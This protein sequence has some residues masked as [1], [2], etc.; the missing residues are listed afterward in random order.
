MNYLAGKDYPWLCDQ[1]KSAINNAALVSSTDEQY[2]DDPE[3]PAMF[4]YDNGLY[5]GKYHCANK[6][7]G[8]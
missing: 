7:E 6:P 5:C 1:C 3:G 2:T 4:V 8:H